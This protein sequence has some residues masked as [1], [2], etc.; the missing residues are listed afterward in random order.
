MWCFVSSWCTQSVWAVFQSLQDCRLL[1]FLIHQNAKTWIHLS[2]IIS[3]KIITFRILLGC[4]A[5]VW[6]SVLL[7]FSPSLYEF[8]GVLLF[9]LF[10]LSLYLSIYLYLYL[11]IGIPVRLR[12]TCR[13][14]Y[15]PIA[16]TVSQCVGIVGF[17]VVGGGATEKC[18]VS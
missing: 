4:M 2:L 12:T 14:L 11:Y 8:M 13:L 18:F 9:L 17:Y 3:L 5:T 15:W 6:V 10:S 1:C 16:Y 7:C